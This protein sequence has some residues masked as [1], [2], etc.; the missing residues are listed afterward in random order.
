MLYNNLLKFLVNF[1][2]KV[3]ILYEVKDAHR[4]ILPLGIRQ[5]SNFK[6]T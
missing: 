3:G 6:E 1:F 4:V 2:I 5:M